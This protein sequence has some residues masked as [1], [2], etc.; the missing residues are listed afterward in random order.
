MLRL[1]AVSVGKYNFSFLAKFM[2]KLIWTG[3]GKFYVILFPLFHSVL[4]QD[5]V[6]RRCGLETFAVRHL[7]IVI[8]PA[9]IVAVEL[10]VICVTSIHLCA[11]K[12]LF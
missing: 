6:L 9:A 10:H 12:R 11:D 7:R 3:S 2:M 8:R 4:V 5:N 1:Q